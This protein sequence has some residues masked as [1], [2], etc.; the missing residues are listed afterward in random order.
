LAATISHS[1][2]GF[3]SGGFLHLS[4]YARRGLYDQNA[5]VGELIYYRELAKLPQGLGSGVYG[6][7]SVEA[8]NI[9]SEL[10]DIAEGDLR[11]GGSLFLGADTLVG[12]LYLGVGASSEGEAAVYLQLSPILRPGRNPR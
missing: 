9:W 1:T 8:G 6:G 3:R 12:P 10:S 7:F 5:L 4:G 11:Y 2:T